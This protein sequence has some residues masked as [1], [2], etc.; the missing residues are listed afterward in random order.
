MFDRRLLL[1][2]VTASCG[3]TTVSGQPDAGAPD[4]APA[5]PSCSAGDRATG[6]CSKLSDYGLFLGNG[7][8]QRPVPGVVPY[9]VI[10]PLFA[11]FAL[12]HRF[13]YLP[14]GTK[15]GYDAAG[16]WTFPAGAIAIKTFAYPK[17]ATQPALGERLIETRLILRG[18]SGWTAITYVWNDAQT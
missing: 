2:A 15:I 10:S 13:L 8:E 11:D 18:D 14:P 12:K 17:D 3:S 5:L 6:K 4:A 9:D 1:L 16:R 7:A